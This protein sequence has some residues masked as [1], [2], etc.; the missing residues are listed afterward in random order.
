MSHARDTPSRP[1]RTVSLTQDDEPLSRTESKLFGP[2]G[3][4]PKGSPDGTGTDPRTGRHVNVGLPGKTPKEVKEVVMTPVSEP[5]V[6]CA[7]RVRKISLT[8]S[9][10][11]NTACTYL[12][13]NRPTGPGGAESRGGAGTA[14]LRTE[15]HAA[16]AEAARLFLLQGAQ[17]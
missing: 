17:I 3:A 12:R 1:R 10:G 7:S 11:G 4:P 8:T 15:G 14:A 5:P 2:S 9:A 16:E 6:G 13:P